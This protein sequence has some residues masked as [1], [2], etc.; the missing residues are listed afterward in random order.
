M[1]LQPKPE[2]FNPFGKTRWELPPLILHPFTDPRRHNEFV[3]TSKAALILSGLLPGKSYDDQQ[4]HEKV[5]ESRYSELRMLFFLGRDLFRW[6]G[7]CAEWA[8]STPELSRH[9]VREQSFATL[10][11]G[12]PPEGVQTKLRNWGVND[13]GTIF[14]RAMGLNTAFRE[15]PE[16]ELIAEGFLRNFHVYA[17]HLFAA[18]QCLTS[19][20]EIRPENFSFE[21]YASGE[22]SRLLERQWSE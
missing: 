16:V 14:R 22:Y 6:A 12:N 5:L 11:V 15:L 18:Y 20:A 2:P 4:F 8:A 1:T 17:D 13:Y 21:L 10:L 19:F 7:Q 9:G 3:E